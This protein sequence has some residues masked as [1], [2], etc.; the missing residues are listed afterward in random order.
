VELT[1]ANTALLVF[2]AAILGALPALTRRWSPRGLHKLVSISAGIFLGS[3]FLH[4]LPELALETAPAGPAER[5]SVTPWVAVLVGF[6][7]LFVVERVWLEKRGGRDGADTHQ[8]LLLATF[9]GLGV[10]ASTMGLS[11]SAIRDNLDWPLLATILGHKAAEAFSLA[12]VFSLAGRSRR[13][14]LLP[15]VLFAAITPAGLLLGD[16]VVDASGPFATILAGFACG[17]F[18][19]VAV[20]DLLPEVFHDTEQSW[21][22]LGWVL[23]GILFTALVLPDGAIVGFLAAG[24]AESAHVFVEMAPFLLL[25]FAIAGILSE[26]LEPELLTRHLAGDDLASVG[27]AALIGAPLPLCSCS[28][29]PVAASLRKAGASKGATSS[30]LIATPETGADSVTVTWALLDPLMTIARPVGAIVSAFITGAAVNLF[31]R[32]RPDEPATAE[33]AVPGPEA[34]EPAAPEDECCATLEAHDGP[35]GAGDARSEREGSFLRRAARYAFVDMIDDLAWLLLVGILLSGVISAAVPA[36]LFEQPIARG[37][38]GLVL[39]LVVGIPIYVCAAASTPIAASL[40]LKGLSPGAALVFLLASPATNAASI[41]AMSRMLGRR[42]VIVHL[43]VLG[44]TTLALGALVD[45]LYPLLSIVPSAAMGPEHGG[46]AGWIA[47]GSA[48]VLAILMLL[49]LVRTRLGSGAP[50]S[51]PDSTDG[52]SVL[53]T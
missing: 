4:L 19:Y 40:I 23:L 6:L 51:V 1:P 29:L 11:L 35:A 46:S 5:P 18:L 16:L 41:V 30:F 25:G 21:T 44:V 47:R 10:H 48:L 27:K 13:R 26:V 37:F 28:V 9:L 38:S 34:S 7:L 14:T 33:P 20:C 8:V 50:R 2:L 49:S 45:A 36:E 12:A 39:M 53:P 32:G 24:L 15:L 42:V 22:K 17:T 31:A 43:A 52:H 3:V